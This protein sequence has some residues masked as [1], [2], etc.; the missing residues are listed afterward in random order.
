MLKQAI[1]EY[2]FW[3]IEAGYCRK[4]WNRTEEI[5]RYFYDFVQR[6]KV[7]MDSV[8]TPSTLSA[9]E[10][11]HK[12]KL[13]T[14]DRVRGLWRYLFQQG[15]INEPLKKKKQLPE[16]YEEYLLYYGQRVLPAQVQGAGKVLSA[17]NVYLGEHAIGLCN[18]KVDDLDNFLALHTRLYTAKVRRN[19][20][21]YLQGFLRYLYYERKILKKDLDPLLVGPPIFAQAK[22]PKFLRPHEVQR[23]FDNSCPTTPWELRAYA[24][25][26]LAYTL[27][28]RSKEISLLKLDDIS[29]RTREVRLCD[30]KNT[31]PL[32]L[33]LPE[34]AVKA[35]A[36][37]IVGARPKSEHRTLFLSLHAPYGPLC[38]AQVAR[39]IT[40]L[41]RRAHVPG[42]AYWLRHTY[43]QNLL[44]RGASI[45]EI[46]EMLGHENIQSAQNYL[47]V[48]IKLMREV[49]FDDGTL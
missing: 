36:A 6:Q 15:K 42:S 19:K 13:Y 12:D 33:P 21:Y 45:F 28:A 41:F 17:L 47:R 5:L 7:P 23:L 30:R 32:T 27:G 11:E 8:F 18:L 49:L 14:G 44:E 31:Q 10:K 1:E 35:M 9:F 29:F 48:N 25:L 37:Y 34:D 22:P 4:T 26:W 20:R 46:K 16:M 39:N 24:M 43:A 38:S 3:M 40:K 2:L